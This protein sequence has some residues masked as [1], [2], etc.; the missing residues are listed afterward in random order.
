MPKDFFYKSFFKI[1]YILENKIIDI[2]LA[3]ICTTKNSFINEGFV[4]TICQVFELNYN[5]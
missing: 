2:I 3:N 1:Q 4:E 5:A